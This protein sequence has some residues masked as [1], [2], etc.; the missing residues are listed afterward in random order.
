M[1]GL[2]FII[3]MIAAGLFLLGILLAWAAWRKKKG[4]PQ[5]PKYRSLF[6]LGVTF[7]PLGIIYEIVFFISGTQVFLVLGLAFIAMGL[8]YL[9]IGLANRNKWEENG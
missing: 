1:S 7:L 5:P 6:I 4:K 9:A 8:S 2:P 3:I